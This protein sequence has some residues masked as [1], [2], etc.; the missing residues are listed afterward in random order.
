MLEGNAVCPE[1]TFSKNEPCGNGF[2]KICKD[3]GKTYT[4]INR[5]LEVKICDDWATRN[6]NKI[7]EYQEKRYIIHF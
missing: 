4:Y 5:K 6:G 7:K 2:N 1:V 3:Y